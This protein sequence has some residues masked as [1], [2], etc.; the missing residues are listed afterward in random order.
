MAHLNDIIEALVLTVQAEHKIQSASGPLNMQL[1]QV[2]KM[3]SV[4]RRDWA[5]SAF[6]ISFKVSCTAIMIVVE[7]TKIYFLELKVCPLLG[8]TA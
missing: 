2:P 8:G 3:L 7:I 5:P 6:C 1:A 4:L